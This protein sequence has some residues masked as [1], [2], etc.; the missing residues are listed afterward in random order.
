VRQFLRRVAPAVFGVSVTQVNLLV[1]TL[2]ASFLI[3]GSVSWLYY[4]DRLVEFPL[5]IFGVAIGTAVSPQLAKYHARQDDQGFSAALDWGLRWMLLIGLPATVG[6]VLLATPLM[7][8]LFEYDEF[9]SDDVAMAGRS[10]MTYALGLVGFT[11]VKVLAP[12]FNTRHDVQTPVR[13]GF[14][15]MSLN[16][17][18][19]PLLAFGVAP[20][21]WAHA[22]LTL[23]T[24]IAALFNAAL[25]L[26]ALRRH[27]IY[28]PHRGWIGFSLRVLAANVAMGAFLVLMQHSHNWHG[29]SS[30]ERIKQ[31]AMLIGSGAGLYAVSLW[32]LGTRPRHLALTSY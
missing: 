12:G 22:G 5:G 14:A 26:I 6:L 21:G 17:L 18:L 27:E 8:T 29:W 13:C 20:P 1:D 25:L 10:L 3:S 19:C 31:L 24:A 9:G 7:S 23:A 30:L 15:S 28:R 32:L 16:A 4:S 11:G 2:A